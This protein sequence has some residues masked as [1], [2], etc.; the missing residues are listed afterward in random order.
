[1]SM[2]FALTVGNAPLLLFLPRPKSRGGRRPE[3][4]ESSRRQ[5]APRCV[6]AGSMWRLTPRT[7]RPGSTRPK[8]R[9]TPDRPIVDGGGAMQDLDPTGEDAAHESPETTAASA[10]Q[11]TPA[12]TSTKRR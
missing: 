5:G 11:P 2:P 7:G 4:G 6:T 8:A 9:D 12:P 1:M 3:R 10:D